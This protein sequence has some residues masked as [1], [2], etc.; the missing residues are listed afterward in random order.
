MNWGRSRGKTG[1]FSNAH[2]TGWPCFQ[3][4][5]P[6]C[7][8]VSPVSFS[9][10]PVLLKALGLVIWAGPETCVGLSP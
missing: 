8:Q 3:L 1:D 7:A 6:T 10:F 5:L 4:W 2:S 9:L